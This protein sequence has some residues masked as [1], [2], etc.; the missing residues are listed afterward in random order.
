MERKKMTK[1]NIIREDA[2]LLNDYIF[3]RTFTKGSP[4]GILKDFLEAVLDM[5][6][7]NVEVL[8][9]EIPKDILEEK[10]SVLD[11]RA[12]LND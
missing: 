4:N 12:K 3:K 11:I 8:N 2:P 7:R 9:A 10:G 6:L 5:K 1:N